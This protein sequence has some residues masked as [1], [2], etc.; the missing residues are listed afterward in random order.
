MSTKHVRTPAD[1]GRFGCS[2][3]V[4]C[5]AP[6]PPPQRN[7]SSLNFCYSAPPLGPAQET[8]MARVR[9]NERNHKSQL[10]LDRVPVTGE[11]IAVGPDHFLEV[12]GVCHYPS[13]APA[14][15]VVTAV[16]ARQNLSGD[17]KNALAEF[18]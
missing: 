3:M 4:V 2:L 1:L 6:A 5:D 17:M 12:T 10:D 16:D 7:D 11:L 13:D 18:A 14:D 15:A 9:I 8:D